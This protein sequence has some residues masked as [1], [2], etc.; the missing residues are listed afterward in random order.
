MKCKEIERIYYVS[1]KND[2][3]VGE[4]SLSELGK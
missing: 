4:I 2:V 1:E 3:I